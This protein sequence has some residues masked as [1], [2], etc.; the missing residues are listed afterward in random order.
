MD[1]CSAAKLADSLDKS[2]EPIRSGRKPDAAPNFM[3]QFWQCASL[4][5]MRQS[6][7]TFL[8]TANDLA[9]A[10]QRQETKGVGLDLAVIELTDFSIGIQTKHNKVKE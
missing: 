3:D 6:G 9:L 8:E 5:H 4:A 2:T 10:V 1:D 7:K